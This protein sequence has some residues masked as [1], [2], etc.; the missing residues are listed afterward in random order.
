M[1]RATWGRLGILLTA[2]I[3]S[4]VGCSGKTEDVRIK[5]CRNVTERLLESMAPITW[6][7]QE[8]GVRQEGDA[9]VRLSFY[10]TKEGYENRPVSSAC[11]FNRNN[12]EASA[13]DHVDP[14]FAY[15]T[16]PY[17]MT[18]ESTPV[19]DDVLAGVVKDEQLAPVVEFIG[20]MKQ[21]FESLRK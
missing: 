8:A 3:V 9:A 15:A 12:L 11:F 6:K 19:P 14:L 4:T 21:D 7:S 18:I 1:D 13:V 5:L 17:A 16:V 20:R 2:A 10:V